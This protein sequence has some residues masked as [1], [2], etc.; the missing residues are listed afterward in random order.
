MGN[1]ARPVSASQVEMLELMFPN[2]ANPLGSVMGGRVMHFIDVAAAIAATRHAGRQCVTASVDHIDFH[3]PVKVGELLVL[4]AS[5]NFAGST[6]VEVGVRVEVE[7]RFTG[8]LKKTSSAYL[9]FVAIGDDGKPHKVPGLICETE[10]DKRR[11]QEAKNRRQ[12]RL[13]KLGKA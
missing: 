2:D 13:E 1:K 7:N 8:E 11:N 3:A 4:K 12:A 9:T 5:V 10:D 6:S